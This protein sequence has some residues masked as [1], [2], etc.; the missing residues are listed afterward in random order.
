MSTARI[1]AGSYLEYKGKELRLV[2]KF[3]ENVWQV[4]C[5]KTKRFQEFAESEI[6]SLLVK[7]EMAI[8]DLLPDNKKLKAQKRLEL[9]TGDKRY[10]KAIMRRD[11]V[12]ATQHLPN[13]KSRLRPVIEETWIKLG[14]K[15]KAP[16][17]ATVIV[18]KNKYERSDGEPMA[19]VDRHLDKGNRRG[20]YCFEVEN[21]VLDAIQT[22]Y[23]A[24]ERG[25]FQD[26]LDCAKHSV[27][28]ENELRGEL[29]KLELPTLALVKRLVKGIPKID[30][31]RARYG[32]DYAR[33]T[34]R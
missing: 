10:Q 22:V 26:T 1:K 25:T 23:M 18:W 11:Y 9:N 17:P 13:T 27:Y 21:L 19:L 31:C 3:E 15:G 12:V 33:N 34:F 14:R 24:R 20:R 30:I 29:N 7:K 5:S 4:E 16:N 2:R 6:L 28:L 8:F 32:Y